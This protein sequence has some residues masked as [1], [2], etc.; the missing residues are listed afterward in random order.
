VASHFDTIVAP[1]TGVGPAAVAIVRLSGPDA[2]AIAAK[3]FSSVPD[4]PQ[5]RH[6]YYGKLE[7]GDEGLLTHFNEGHSFT[8]EETSE[9]SCHGSPAAVNALVMS[10]IKAGARMAEPGEFTQRAFMNGRMDLTE[11][12]GIRETIEAVT[13]SQLRLANLQREGMLRL[14]ITTLREQVLRLLAA[15]EATVDFEEE[16]GALDRVGTHQDLD[17]LLERVDKLLQMAEIGRI[18][19]NGLRIAIVGPPN[20]GKSS[21]LNAILREERS[22]VTEVPGTTR[23]FVEEKIDLNGIPVVLI[24]TAG[25]RE[26]KDKAEAI[27]VERSKAQ[28]ANA[29]HIW[30]V[31]DAAE[32]FTPADS[33]ICASLGRP[34]TIVANK[35]DLKAPPKGHVGVSAKTGSGLSNLADTVCQIASSVPSLPLPAPNER[36]TLLLE[37]TR[38]QLSAALDTL[39]ND[40]PDDLLSVNLREAVQLLGEI[41]GETASADMI[42]T[43]FRSFCIGK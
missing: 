29:D 7:S 17:E 40:L 37:E 16:I 30:Y 6:V 33:Q 12:E 41:T 14:E 15:V 21:L 13:A 26:T 34:A 3:V 20:A 32:G 36:H 27:G 39:E 18:V 35:I 42:D 4:S 31:Y 23:D 43:I 9:I 2:W 24:D 5:P 8:G 11:A 38:A 28:A 1:I 22:I 19:R 10:C 25:L